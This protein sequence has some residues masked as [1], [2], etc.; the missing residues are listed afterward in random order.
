MEG[1]EV[2]KMRRIYGVSLFTL[3]KSGLP[4]NKLDI[5]P[6]V[7]FSTMKARCLSATRNQGVA[8]IA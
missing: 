8:T 6:W 5:P 3:S 7:A 1:S 2:V 4:G